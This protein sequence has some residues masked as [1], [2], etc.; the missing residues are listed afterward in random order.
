MI[1]DTAITEPAENNDTP[2]FQYVENYLLK[3]KCGMKIADIHSITFI[4]TAK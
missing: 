4:L 1:C 2:H 3:F